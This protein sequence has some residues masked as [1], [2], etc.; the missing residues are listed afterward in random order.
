MAWQVLLLRL[1][2]QSTLTA[3]PADYV[4]PP[5][6]PFEDVA[7]SIVKAGEKASVKVEVA[8]NAG[9]SRLVVLRN[10]DFVI[11]AELGGVMLVDRV[12]L[13]VLGSDSAMPLVGSLA[14]ATGTSAIDCE[15]DMVLDADGVVPDTLR[16]WQTRI[17]ELS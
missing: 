13:R 6:G 4:P 1:P 12:L 8:T 16:Q 9:G 2:P 17:D 11:E 14:L 7:V 10:D 15:T 3:L 5:I